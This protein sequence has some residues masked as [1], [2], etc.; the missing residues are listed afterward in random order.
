MQADM[1]N[2][3]IVDDNPGELETYTQ[4]LDRFSEE[5]HFQISC[6]TFTEIEPAIEALHKTSFDG[7]IIDLRFGQNEDKGNE[8]IDEISH[9]LY[10]M[11]VVVLTGTPNAADHN[12][13]KNMLVLKKGNENASI[14]KIADYFRGIFVTGITRIMG[15]NGILEQTLQKVFYESFLAQKD[16]W[17]SY[18]K[19]NYDNI[20]EA[21]LRHTL[22]YLINLLNQ[23]NRKY[24]PLENYLYPVPKGSIMTGMIYTRNNDRTY[25]LI[26]NPPCDIA[27]QNNG[28]RKVNDILFVEIENDD[29]SYLSA[30]E[31]YKKTESNN[32][33]KKVLNHFNN[34]ALYYHWLPK[35]SFFCGGKINFR[36]ISKQPISKIYDLYTETGIQIAPFF[37]KEI[38]NNYSY[39]YS[40]Q[41][42]PEIDK[43]IYLKILIE[44]QA[45]S[46]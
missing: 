12:L 6:E 17:I 34:D 33:K 26:I 23:G 24:L 30:L 11:P 37:M 2:L 7:A 3:L 31:D 10:R 14:D 41:G 16:M 36:S 25:H 8:L 39:Y 35:T 19:Y 18:S 46:S 5:N 4:S 22:Q 9:S 21:L 32:K 13:L 1:M 29:Q 43:D 28:E 27:I 20:K 38:L 44:T 40:R 45:I 15:K 42:Q